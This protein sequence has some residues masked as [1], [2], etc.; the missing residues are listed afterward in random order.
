MPWLVIGSLTFA[1]IR[2]LYP[3]VSRSMSNGRSRGL[4]DFGQS[5]REAQN[6]NFAAPL[7]DFSV[8]PRA[9][10]A[11]RQR[12]EWDTRDTMNNRLW[13]DVQVTGAMVVTPAALAAHPTGGAQTSMPSAAR[14]DQRSYVAPGYFPDAPAPR[15][16]QL[17]QRPVLPPQSVFGN[18][19]TSSLDTDHNT[20]REFRGVVKEEN[21]FRAEDVS[22]RT[23]ERMFQHQWVSPLASKQVVISQLEAAEKL[24]PGRDDY[25]QTYSPGP[26]V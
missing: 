20:A 14:Q 12:V 21:R 4:V 5:P 15:P 11:P 17:A 6:R 7:P 24:R 25:R 23:M 26:P 18:A 2:L 13:A 1:F 9:T 10:E 3:A 22:T 8:M 19:F 16:G